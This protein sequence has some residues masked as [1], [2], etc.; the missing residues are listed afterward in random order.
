MVGKNKRKTEVCKSL[1]KVN[2]QLSNQAR[3]Q[4]SK[5]ASKE[6]NK[7]LNIFNLKYHLQIKKYVKT[8]QEIKIKNIPVTKLISNNYINSL[9][10]MKEILIM[11]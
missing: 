3:K 10:F 9:D 8:R 4:A 11:K 6:E 1:P 7:V 2:K 5:Q